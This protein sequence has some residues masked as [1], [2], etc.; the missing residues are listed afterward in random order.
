MSTDREIARRALDLQARGKDVPLLEL[1]G[2]V[3][4]SSQKLDEGESPAL[5]AHLDAM[6]M[7]LLPEDVAGV[8]EEAFDELL[9]ELRDQVGE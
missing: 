7:F 1:P 5:I 6:S 8:S 3:R 2:Y 9:C 4:W